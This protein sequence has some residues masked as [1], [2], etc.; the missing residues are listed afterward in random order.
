[1]DGKLELPRIAIAGF[2]HETNTFSPVS[3]S[4]A[5]FVRSDGWPGLTEGD[6]VL[7]VFR[8]MNIPIGGAIRAA[9]GRAELVPILWASA[10]PSNVVS[11]E[12][13]ETVS[14][15]IV[16]RIIEALPLDGVYLDLH[17]A[18]ATDRHEDAEGELLRRVRDV[19][20]PATPVAVSLDLHANVTEEMAEAADIVTIFRTYPHL[21]MAETGARAFNLLLD[22]IAT[23]LK[24]RTAFRK[25][26]YIIPIH[27]QCTTSHP[28][29]RLYGLL[30]HCRSLRDPHA[31]VA[32]GFPPADIEQC[33]PAIVTVGN[34]QASVDT[35]ADALEKAFLDAAN[36]F[37]T[38]LLPPDEAV[39]LA[40]RSG[41]PGTPAVLADV[42]DNSGAGATSDTTGL[43]AALVAGGALDCAL[44]ALCD[45]DAAEAAHAAGVGGEIE[46]ALGGKIGGP[47]NPP[48]EGCFEVAALGD[49]NFEFTGEMMAGC[50]AEIGPVAALRV[51]D[52]GSDVRVVVTSARIQCVDRSLFNH[53]GIDPQG[54]AVIAVKSTVH[55]R[56]DFE[57]IA[58]RVILV[59]APGF[60]P[61]ILDR[62]PYRR[63]RK[64]VRLL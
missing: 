34:S 18:M 21:D 48:F 17:G 61:C 45:A 39:A 27:A 55:F 43:L 49:G 52:G 3:A 16:S 32:L 53:A 60:H 50:R 25:L 1:M 56:A 37:R 35:K 46:L 11:G 23:D 36:E 20:G 59:E 51:V 22:A 10:E 62:I 63:L 44:A 54:L 31:D 14:T 33:G 5:D 2:Q 24:P 15:K 26:P 42:Q 28:A 7:P 64:G 6:D 8:N 58:S 57:P 41:Q 13:F 29:D 4:L 40:V 19:V 47:E 38:E 12:A 9:E 30:E